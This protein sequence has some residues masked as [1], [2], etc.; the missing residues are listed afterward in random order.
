MIIK[1][2][3]LLKL[4]SGKLCKELQMLLSS[5]VMISRNL[6]IAEFGISTSVFHRS[7][8]EGKGQFFLIMVEEKTLHFQG[9]K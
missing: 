1:F 8:L 3:F 5:L 4:S 6:S 2:Q 7:S 9:S